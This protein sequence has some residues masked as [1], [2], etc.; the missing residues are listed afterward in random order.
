MSV[1]GLL[2]VL[3]FVGWIGSWVY[4]VSRYDL[5][6]RKIIGILC[7]PLIP[8]ALGLTMGLLGYD[9]VLTRVA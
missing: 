5:S 2:F 3:T 9:F 4:V 8:C 1:Q 6:M 7:L